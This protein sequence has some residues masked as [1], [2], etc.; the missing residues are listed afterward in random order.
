MA[1][2]Y[3]PEADYL[4]LLFL[5]T[6]L[7]VLKERELTD[8]SASAYALDYDTT[9]RLSQAETASARNFSKKFKLRAKEDY[10][11][12]AENF[13]DIRITLPRITRD[14]PKKIGFQKKA[15]SDASVESYN[16]KIRTKTVS[17]EEF[18]EILLYVRDENT[19]KPLILAYYL[20]NN[21]NLASELAL[22]SEILSPEELNP[23]G[24]RGI[25]Y[26]EVFVDGIVTVLTKP[27][28]DY[29]EALSFFNSFK[30]V[31]KVEKI[32]WG[33]VVASFTRKNTV[34]LPIEKTREFHIEKI[35]TLSNNLL[36][37]YYMENITYSTV[38]I[39]QLNALTEEQYAEMVNL[40]IEYVNEGLA[41]EEIADLL[42][43]FVKEI[44]NK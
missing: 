30:H 8:D 10:L 23:K 28:A 25:V 39:R 6:S 34:P 21:A 12:L 41:F 35:R 32:K 1:Q 29:K 20:T 31:A 44:L 9:H 36:S 5:A 17:H 42:R 7:D 13:A 38:L 15:S 37:D 24:A 14:T 4:V 22:D 43:K 16:V 19:H 18:T 40:F 11:R 2:T 33:K 27:F 26:Y 3:I